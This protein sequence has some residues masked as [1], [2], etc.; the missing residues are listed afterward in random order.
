MKNLKLLLTTILLVACTP[1]AGPEEA[2]RQWI[3]AAQTA[4]EERDRGTLIGMISDSYVDAR[5]NRRDDIDK[6]LRVYFLRSHKIV[7]ASTIDQ[8]ELIDDSAASVLL[9]VG[10][11]G[12]DTGLFGFSADAYRFELELAKR[13][14][15]WLLIGSRWGALGEELR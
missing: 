3:D 4:A 6:I 1:P 2:V 12:G 11:A 7:L 10:M 8:L 5:G 15:T 13:A 9:T 14:D